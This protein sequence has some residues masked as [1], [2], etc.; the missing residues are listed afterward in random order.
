MN[1][2]ANFILSR[3]DEVQPSRGYSNAVMNDSQLL[4]QR[5]LRDY[6]L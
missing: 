2:P 6:A 1:L 4:S 3:W 5:D